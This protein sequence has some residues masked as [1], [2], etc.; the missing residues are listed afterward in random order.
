MFAD[1]P[2]LLVAALSALKSAKGVLGS[3]TEE[4]HLGQLKTMAETK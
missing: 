3:M 2:H 4:V 1:H